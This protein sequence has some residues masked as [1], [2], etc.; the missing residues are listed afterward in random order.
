MLPY[1][2]RNL[3]TVQSLDLSKD[4][5]PRNGESM[6]QVYLWL[7]PKPVLL[8]SMVKP[9]EKDSWLLV[10]AALTSLPK[11]RGGSQQMTGAGK[12]CS[13]VSL[14]FPCISVWNKRWGELGGSISVP[15]KEALSRVQGW[16]CV[17]LSQQQNICWH[18]LQEWT[19]ALLEVS[20]R[21]L[22][23]RF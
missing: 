17:F 7:I 16:A 13:L 22:K 6:T 9:K 3:D 10:G 11:R 1:P 4:A 20:W 5:K 15:Q 12:D 14:L 8:T 23:T 21:A 19:A 2:H 18:L